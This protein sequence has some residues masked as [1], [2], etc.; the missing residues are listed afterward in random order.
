MIWLDP[1]G[2]SLALFPFRCALKRLSPAFYRIRPRTVVNGD[3]PERHRNSLNHVALIFWRRSGLPQKLVH[4]KMML[5]TKR[6]CQLWV[7]ILV[8][9]MMFFNTEVTRRDGNAL[10][11]ALLLSGFPTCS[12]NW[13]AIRQATPPL[14]VRY[15]EKSESGCSMSMM[16]R[17]SVTSSAPPIFLPCHFSR[18]SRFPRR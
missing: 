5:F 1:V 13:Q 16:V 14:K 6:S 17:F 10:P 3:G 15:S 12:P 18:A 9:R 2:S 8:R 7:V 11:F 4:F